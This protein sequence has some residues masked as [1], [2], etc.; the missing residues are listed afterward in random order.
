[1]KAV[2]TLIVFVL[3]TLGSDGQT[4]NEGM[5]TAGGILTAALNAPIL[6]LYPPEAY[7]FQDIKVIHQVYEGLMRPDPL[8]SEPVL[9]LAQSFQVSE[10]RLTYRFDLRTNARFHDNVCF[11]KGIGRTFTAHDV[12]TCFERL[13]IAT[14]NNTNDWIFGELVVGAEA[15]HEASVFGNTAVQHVSGIVV[16]NDSV[17][18][19]QL[20][21]PSHDFLHRLALPATYIYP[22]EAIEHYGSELN[23]QMVGTGPFRQKTVEGTK[24]IELERH[25]NYWDTDE[26]DVQLPYLDGIRFQVIKSAE[27]QAALLQSNQ[28]HV[29]CPEYIDL[30]VFMTDTQL[31]ASMQNLQLLVGPQLFTSFY[32]FGLHKELFANKAL[33]QAINYAI[34]REAIVKAVFSGRGIA[35][36]NG[37]TPPGIEGYDISKIDGYAFNPKKAKQLLSAAGY[38]DGK[39]LPVVTLNINNKK[40]E[41]NAQVAFM[42]QQMLME[43]LNIEVDIEILPFDDHLMIVAA[44][45]ASFWRDGWI[46]DYANPEN[47]LHLLYGKEVPKNVNA[48][49]GINTVRFTDE[50]FDAHYE[51]AQRT[52]NLGETLDAFME[53]EQRA[54]D[55][56][57]IVPLYYLNSYLIATKAVQNLTVNL[58]NTYYFRSVFL[59]K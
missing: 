12:K 24:L 48:P 34:D 18:E 49:S 14:E 53:A 45:E 4:P 31:K 6:S 29:S 40:R 23:R 57:A 5:P 20:K 21:Q 7:A 58:S 56:A 51:S 41:V 19:I 39:G 42:V 43:Q 37:I 3:S 15:L 52:N 36:T 35:A 13:C 17:L 28:L 33:R 59:R 22:T 11:P 54:I 2:L 8:T 25:P 1:M 55:E 46:S 30:G 16:V 32:G 10:D 47:F 38:P 50:E 44:G 27:K 9:G 26:N